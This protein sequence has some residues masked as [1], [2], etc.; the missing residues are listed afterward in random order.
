M[1]ATWKHSIA[2]SVLVEP[3][4]VTNFLL[5]PFGF[6]RDV[7]PIILMHVVVVMR[8]YNCSTPA[9]LVKVLM[10]S[11]SQY[12]KATPTCSIHR[13]SWVPSCV[14]KACQEQS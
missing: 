8:L 11:H 13:N 10:S 3:F 1:S 2:F 14:P 6:S 5:R 4:S 12:V 7:N 9:S